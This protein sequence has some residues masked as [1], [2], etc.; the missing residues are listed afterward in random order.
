MFSRHFCALDIPCKEHY[1]NCCGDQMVCT[2]GWLLTGGFNHSVEYDVGKSLC[3][4]G[5]TLGLKE[6]VRRDS[7]GSHHPT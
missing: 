2:F 7:L 4:P 5:T 1:D 3:D 6:K